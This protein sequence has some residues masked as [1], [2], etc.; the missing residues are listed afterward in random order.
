MASTGRFKNRLNIFFSINIIQHK[1]LSEKLTILD[2]HTQIQFYHHL[3]LYEYLLIKK[4]YS[5]LSLDKLVKLN[6]KNAITTII[7]KLFFY[8]HN[9]FIKVCIKKS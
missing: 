3:L 2:S 4:I 1:L 5:R 6:N 9:K 8:S 7:Y